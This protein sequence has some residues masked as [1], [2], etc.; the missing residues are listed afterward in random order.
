MSSRESAASSEAQPR[1]CPA[2]CTPLEGLRAW[3]DRHPTSFAY[4]F[5]EDSLRRERARLDARAL[6]HRVALARDGLLELL[7]EKGI[8]AS[9][10]TE[11]V[12]RRNVVRPRSDQGA[13]SA[14]VDEQDAA[15]T[16]ATKTGGGVRQK[17]VALAFPP[18][19]EFLVAFLACEACGVVA[20]PARP[21]DPTGG[22]ERF[23]EER[24]ALIAVAAASGARLVLTS[25]AYA[26]AFGLAE[27]RTF[28]RFDVARRLFARPASGTE[29]KKKENRAV[30]ALPFAFV[31]LERLLE[32]GG[33]SGR[34]ETNAS[35]SFR[36]VFPRRVI[37]D[38]AEEPKSKREKKSARRGAVAF[39]QFTSGSTGAP[40]GV[41]VG[42][43]HLKTNC[44]LIR[45]RLG[46][47]D[48]DANVSWLPQFHDM[49]LVGA[50]LVP[51]TIPGGGGGGAAAQAAAAAPSPMEEAESR[52]RARATTSR[53][54]TGVFYSPIAF[55]RDPASWMRV[56]SEYRATM[57]QGPD[58][59]YRLCAMRFGAAPRLSG[60]VP[61]FDRAPTKTLNLSRL[62]S[63]LNASE[64]AQPDTHALFASTFAR[65]GWNPRS[66]RAGYGLAESV[67]YVCDGPARVARID[68]SALEKRG[69]TIESAS[70]T[71]PSVTRTADNAGDDAASISRVRDDASV[72]SCGSVRSRLSRRDARDERAQPARKKKSDETTIPDARRGASS[73]ALDPDVRVVCPA[74]CVELADGRV[75]EIWV[76]GGSVAFGYVTADGFT[77]G[78]TFGCEAVLRA[79]AGAAGSRGGSR[80]TRRNAKRIGGYL[81]TGD[82]GF[83]DGVT[84]EVF[85][86]GRIKD[87]FKVNGRAYAPEDIERV[88]LDAKP[89]VFRRGGVAAFAFVE[90]RTETADTDS[91]S[92]STFA[93]DSATRL[94]VVAEV[95]DEAVRSGRLRR[96]AEV[97]SLLNDV[98]HVVLAVHGLRLRR[99]DV[100]LVRAGT[101]PK[102]SSGKKRR[103]ETRRWFLDGRFQKLRVAGADAL[104]AVSAEDADARGDV[105]FTE[106]SKRVGGT[107]EPPEPPEPLDPLETL[108]ALARDK[109]ERACVRHMETCLTRFADA[110]SRDQASQTSSTFS[111]GTVAATTELVASG[112]LDSFAAVRFTARLEFE[113][114]VA[115]PPTL[116]LVEAPTPRR[117]A[118]ALFRLAVAEPAADRAPEAAETERGAGPKMERRADP[119]PEPEPEP[120]GRRRARLVAFVAR[121]AVVS[122]LFLALAAGKKENRPEAR[123]RKTAFFRLDFPDP[124]RAAHARFFEWRAR[125]APAQVAIGVIV[126]LAGRA[127][128]W[129]L[130]SLAFSSRSA[131]RAA[132]VE[133]TL[134]I[135]RR[136]AS[137]AASSHLLLTHGLFGFAFVVAQCGAR[138][139]AEKAL[140]RVG[141][142]AARRD[143]ATDAT[144]VRVAW[145]LCVAELILL[146]AFEAWTDRAGAVSRSIGRLPRKTVR[147]G[148][149]SAAGTTPVSFLTRFL[150]RGALAGSTF[151][152]AR[153]A[154]YVA[155]RALD[156]G[157]DRIHDRESTIQPDT[158]AD[159]FAFAAHPAT[160]QC[161][162]LVPH[163]KYAARRK[164]AVSFPA[165]RSARIARSGAEKTD[166]PRQKSASAFGV[167]FLRRARLLA[168]SLAPLVAWCLVVD[169][170][171]AAG[172]RPRATFFARSDAVD[173]DKNKNRAL[174]SGLGVLELAQ[175][176]ALATASWIT[177]HAV[178]GVPRAVAAAFDDAVGVTD[179][180]FET[181][182]LHKQRDSSADSNG[183]D[184]DDDD[185]A[186]SD[187][188]D[189]DAAAIV[190]NDTP[191]FWPTASRAPSAFWRH[192]HASFFVF[193]FS[194]VY[195]P[196]RGGYG[197]VFASVAFSTAFHGFSAKWLAWGAVTAASLAAEKWVKSAFREK[198]R[199]D[200]RDETRATK[201]SYATRALRRALAQTAT[202]ATFVG[203]AAF[204]G[205]DARSAVKVLLWGT[206]VSAV[207]QH[208]ASVV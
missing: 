176:I 134:A 45:S 21:P 51:L 145:A 208:A 190:P 22:V 67:V 136:V 6:A 11:D 73:R 57:T 77:R 166:E 47:T 86:V 64:R 191:D 1:A 115:L 148:S 152:P 2:L 23:V 99:R 161:G 24:E 175:T 56:A 158:F 170:M 92:P 173:R 10:W 30:F 4:A 194:R 135:E 146:N 48:R 90:R 5:L 19:L 28:L 61:G 142:R 205:L 41:V 54:A 17:T 12:V 18:G 37:H 42:V 207:W 70:A 20:V 34:S 85:V 147:F 101:T 153:A 168:S 178:F 9:P 93:L 143:D 126:W 79:D 62:R 196:M 97:A 43:T 75:G 88:I 116:V 87:R 157:L 94:G 76:R 163:A 133:E 160:C 32:R 177:S 110:F 164:R 180:S 124:E 35:S 98:R 8:R 118:K 198:K 103:D 189:D 169:L 127:F 71:S 131:R 187:D 74:T 69:V 95:R 114:G 65:H 14:F 203:P 188:D 27:A 83:I 111:R 172:Y 156:R 154:R 53:S 120:R 106:T 7:R 46:V 165:P 108:R 113:L 3:L 44:A 36:N 141:A 49:G 40:K 137:F 185:D 121:A 78:A 91:P 38:G 33:R 140:V 89:G 105:F 171:Y 52:A 123:K 117:L 184:D 82:S 195:A 183:F 162:P 193:Y 202:V 192:F 58:F 132:R 72:S 186:A 15:S 31:T 167:V 130:V 150:A 55:A 159:A 68:R 13:P 26:A 197:G 102:T 204:P 128:R 144:R 200:A 66:M 181:G 206:L 96:P 84:G 29:R 119:E 201:Y 139:V 60:R 25:R 179:A 125:V 63:C 80:R 138:F 50:W 109:G 182:C 100:E 122:T 199:R 59:A 151:T 16:E 129:C 174:T 149:M 155:V 81:R 39:V 112:S 107:P 104:D